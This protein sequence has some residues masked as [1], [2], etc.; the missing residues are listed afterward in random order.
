M[1]TA[2][3]YDQLLAESTPTTH[4][5]ESRVGWLSHIALF[6]GHIDFEIAECANNETI[7]R[8]IINDALIPMS[9]SQGCTPRSDG[10]CL[11][12]EFIDYQKQNAYPDSN[13]NFACFGDYNVSEPVKNGSIYGN[14]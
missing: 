5:N 7:I 4:F 6:G 10:A 9:P 11:L 12:T 13:F 8:T 2:L 3:N 14:F 1:L